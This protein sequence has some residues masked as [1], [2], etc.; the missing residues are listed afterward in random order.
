VTGVDAS[1]PRLAV[2]RNLVKRLGLRHVR[3]FNEDACLFNVPPPSRIGA[4]VL[5]NV[6]GLESGMIVKPMYASKLLRCD[7]QYA[8]FL[9]EKVIVDAEC[10]HDGSIAHI[11]KQCDNGWS[12]G[13]IRMDEDVLC[14]LQVLFLLT[15]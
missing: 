14:E 11:R 9:Y 5:R 8:G 2:T 4:S 3:L 12:E 7:L 1:Y 13:N 10:T 6:E 15:Y